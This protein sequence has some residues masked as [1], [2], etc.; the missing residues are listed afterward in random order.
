MAQ[1]SW[2]ESVAA[3]MGQ[4]SVMASRHEE[5]QGQGLCPPLLLSSGGLNLADLDRMTA[6]ISEPG[7]TQK[8]VRLL[9][10]QARVAPALPSPEVTKVL[11]S[12][13]MDEGAARAKPEWLPTVC[14]HR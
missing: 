9:R 5:S 6:I 2:H 1:R 7:F 10:E 3:E 4:L 11:Q 12:F 8:H 13:I 14:N